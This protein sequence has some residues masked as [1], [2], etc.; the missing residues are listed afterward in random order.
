MNQIYKIINKSIE[1]IQRAGFLSGIPSGFVHIDKHTNGW[2]NSDLIVLASR[3]SMGKS[4]F[5]ISMA[6]NISV[7]FDIGVA[8]F[9]LEMSSEQLVSRIISIETGITL[10]KL[11]K[12]N[13]EPY[14][15][16]IVNSN[17]KRLCKAP[18][19][20]DDTPSLSLN[21]LKTRVI[22]LIKEKNIK[23]IFI[24]CI[25]LMRTG[26]KH[27]V[28][29]EQEISYISRN[30]KGLAK[31]LDLPIIALSQLSRS[32]ET[33]GGSKRPLLHDLRESGSIEYDADIVSFIFR[34]EYYGMTEWDD[35]DHTP[36]EGQG[37]FIIAKNRNGSLDNIR[38]K[39]RRHLAEFSDLEKSN[40]KE[41]DKSMNAFNEISGSI[42]PAD[43]F[44]AP[45]APDDDVPF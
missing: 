11:R 28:N 39:F 26:Q 27:L 45:V 4:S 20:V 42:N 19:F 37:E 31:E 36:C 35:D 44:D 38:L 18:I 21:D 17:T 43:A 3:P 22:K 23:I 25:Q 5:A 2:Q 24:D 6:R 7:D 33:R 41:L 10:E 29:R 32:V 13:L 30:L 12:G 34:P 16:E 8:Y 14:E 9:T 40:K 1:K 15:L